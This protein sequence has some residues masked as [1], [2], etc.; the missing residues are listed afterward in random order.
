[1]KVKEHC[2]DVLRS[3]LNIP[4]PWRSGRKGRPKAPKHVTPFHNAIPLAILVEIT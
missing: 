1:M 4:Q 2:W 3:Q